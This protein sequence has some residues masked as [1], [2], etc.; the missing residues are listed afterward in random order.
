MKCPNC[1][2]GISNPWGPWETHEF[3]NYS[4]GAAVADSITSYTRRRPVRDASLE[5]DVFVPGIQAA[6]TSVIAG[7]SGGV[8]S[9]LLKASRPLAAGLGAGV[10]ALVIAWLILLR[11]HRDLLWET[12]EV[13]PASDKR[14]PEDPKPNFTT[15]EITDPQQ[16]QIRYVDVPLND[17]EL[18]SLARG[19]LVQHYHFSRRSLVEAQVIAKEKYTDVLDIF[20]SGGLARSKGRT[21]NAGVELTGAGRAFLKQYL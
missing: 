2:T 16:R 15:V 5:A 19:L 21:T 20:L 9:A 7:F 6:I 12:E 17:A 4:F 3:A 8:G 14:N 1:G 18:R 10:L 13:I 11:D